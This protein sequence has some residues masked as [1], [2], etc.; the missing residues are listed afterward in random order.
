[1][2]I[3]EEFETVSLILRSQAKTR[4]V[5]A[6]ALSVIKAERQIRKLF[7]HLVYQFPVFRRNDVNELQ[8]ILAAERGVYFE[9]FERGFDAI[10]PKSVEELVSLDYGRLRGRIK[11]AIK[12]RNKIFHGQLTAHSLNRRALTTFVEDIRAWCAR[13]SEVATAEVGYDGFGRNSFTKSRLPNLWMRYKEQFIS[14]SDYIKFIDEHM[15]RR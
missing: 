10:Y 7:T 9:G 11:E 12:H 6:F 14:T 8:S 1:M 2:S 5:D 4:G 3:E 13:L 15:T